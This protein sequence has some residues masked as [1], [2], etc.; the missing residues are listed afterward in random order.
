MKTTGLT[1]SI[2]AVVLT[3]T[4]RPV[5]ALQAAPPDAEQIASITKTAQAF[6]DAFDKGDAKAVAAFW[7]PDGDYVQQ[8]GRVLKGRAAIEASFAELF[9]AHKGLKLGIESSS[10]NVLTPDTA[11]EDGNT[12]VIP[13]DG[14]VPTV[15]RYTN[16]LVKQDGKWLLASVRDAAYV[17]PSHFN[18]LRPLEWVTGEWV[19]ED[20][21][22]NVG[23]AVFEWTPDQ[24]FL[25]STQTVS[26]GDTIISRVTEW[27]GW[28]PASKQIES[29]AFS[30]D[31]SVSE[32]VWSQDGDQWTIKTVTITPE[33]KK[34]TATS[35]AK[36]SGADGL[37]WQAKESTLDGKAMPA[38]PATKMK[39]V[40]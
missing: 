38:A 34:A 8:D 40:K 27:I 33:G 11:V 17:P 23:R 3:F 20:E 32:S 6:I 7:T 29:R 28:N 24:N 16:V 4:L 26:N 19:D 31:G 39:R 30:S 9:A 13:A 10:L 14:G 37:T 12:V 5:S 36:R 25:V 18:E 2:I 21:N 22:G 35:T 1:R 15:A